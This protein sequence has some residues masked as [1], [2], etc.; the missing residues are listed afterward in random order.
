MKG[1]NAN[2]IISGFYSLERDGGCFRM[3]FLFIL[4]DDNTNIFFIEGFR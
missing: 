4:T 1:V 3:N 2:P